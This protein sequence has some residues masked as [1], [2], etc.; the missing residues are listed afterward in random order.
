MHC[1]KKMSVSTLKD[2]NWTIHDPWFP[3]ASL[4]EYISIVHSDVTF[5]CLFVV[6]LK[7]PRPR[8]YLYTFKDSFDYT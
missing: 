1:N 6:F 4:T 7:K 5:S 2:I 8:E 3:L